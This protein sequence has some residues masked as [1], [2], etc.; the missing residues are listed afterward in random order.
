LITEHSPITLICIGPLTNIALLFYYYSEIVDSNLISQLVIMGG[1]LDKWEFNFANDPSATDY[2]LNL[3]IPTAI[4]G[5]EVCLAQKFTR[6]HYNILRKRETAR[7]VYLT[8]EIKT[9]LKLNELFLK[10]EVKGFYPVDCVAI[11]YSLHPEWFEF[12]KLP[13]HLTNVHKNNP[14]KLDFSTKSYINQELWTKKD[15][16]NESEKQTWV[17]WAITIDS[18]K[19]MELLIE[20]LY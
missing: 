5:Y 12:K 8:K 17:D 10:G 1:A 16:L 15:T 19:F 18:E 3:P 11:T 14:R 20:R 4:C 2:V 7:S 13:I 9:W 6:S